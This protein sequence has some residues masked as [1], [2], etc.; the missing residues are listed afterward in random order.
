MSGYR[1]GRELG[2]GGMAVVYAGWQDELDRPVAL[3]VLAAHLAGD[4]EFRVR[5]LREARIAARLDHP[6][7]VRTLDVTE[8]DGLP[9][10]VMELLPGRTLEGGSLSR[11][12]AA[13]VADALA[14]A[15]ARGIV[16]RDLKPANLL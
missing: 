3:K 4:P 15:H 8:I 1:L 14:Y 10:I 13:T 5:F 6:H 12:E 7:L 16:H 9:C 2:R 11:D